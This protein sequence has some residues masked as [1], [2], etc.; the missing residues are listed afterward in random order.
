MYI[1]KLKNNS[2]STRHQVNIKKSL[3]CK[4]SKIVKYLTVGSKMYSG[5]GFS[6]NITIG[7]KGSGIK[8]LYRDMRCNFNKSFALLI[9]V[10]YDSRKSA[11]VS[12][13]YNFLT[14][15]FFN[16]LHTFNTFPGSILFSYKIYPELRLGSFNK[17]RD[18][19]TGS[20]VHS[21]YT[22]DFCSQYIRSAGTFGIIVQKDVNFCKI[23]MP[24]GTVKKFSVNTLCVLGKIS[25]NLNNRVV[26]GKAGRSRLKNNRPHVR[27]VAMN[28]VDHPHGG[29]TSGGIPSVT[30]WGI[31]TK[32]KPTRKKNV[33][34]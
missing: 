32:G 14:L 1:F 26:L 24:S 9:T 15:K 21:L 3:L 31:P 22:N 29:Q 19:P 30:P 8:K 7:H 6:G 27:G 4:N 2:N 13:F 23:K 17:L 33:K 10:F 25:N 12:L 16:S 20:C 28:P 18:I 5:R 34:I 11:F